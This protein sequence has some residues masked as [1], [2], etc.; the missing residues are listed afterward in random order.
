MQ[1]T[2]SIELLIPVQAV[3]GA[4]G[5]RAFVN[6]KTGRAHVVDKTKGKDAFI[7]TVKLFASEQAKSV[8]WKIAAGAYSAYYEFRFARPNSHYGTGKNEGFVKPKFVDAPHG[9]K[10]D[11]TNLVKRLEDALT[12]VIW[13][14]DR[15]VDL[16]V[17]AKTWH[18]RNEI[19]VIVI[20]SE[21]RSDFVS[22]ALSAFGRRIYQADG[23]EWRHGDARGLAGDSEPFVEPEFVVLGGRGRK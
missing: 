4:N 21:K 13:A 18:H 14:D 22:D 9:Q 16:S 20:R 19:R 23:R 2:D 8:G 3:P 17:A 5:K 10:P 7:G 15:S 11:V 1:P 6:P 12:D